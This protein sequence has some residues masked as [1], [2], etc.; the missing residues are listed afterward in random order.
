MFDTSIRVAK[1]LWTLSAGIARIRVSSRPEKI[2]LLPHWVAK[3]YPSSV[4]T[5]ITRTRVASQP[6]SGQ[7][8]FLSHT[9]L[10][11]LALE[12]HLPHIQ[13]WHNLK[14]MDLNFFAYLSDSEVIFVPRAHWTGITRI[15]TWQASVCIFT[16]VSD[17]KYVLLDAHERRFTR[18]PMIVNV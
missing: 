5:S 15:P 2:H 16:W 13:G 6:H 11:S 3:I 17:L 9:P 4:G 1:I 12:W 14:N 18:I 10:A 7:F 8:S